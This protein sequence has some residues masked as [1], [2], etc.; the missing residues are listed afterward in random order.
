MVVKTASV[1]F[2]LTNVAVIPETFGKSRTLKATVVIGVFGAL[3]SLIIKGTVVATWKANDPAS[4]NLPFREAGALMM[5][6]A[7]VVL[8]SCGR[9]RRPDGG[10]RRPATPARS[11][12]LEVADIM[13]G[14]NAGV[15]VG[16]IL[17]FWSG[18]S[19]TGYLAIVYFE[20]VQHA[21]AN[22]Q[23]VAG[24][25]SGVPVVMFGLGLG[26]LLSRHLS[27][28]QVAI[29][30]PAAGTVVSLVQFTTTHI[31]QTVV[32]AFVGAPLVHRLRHL[33][34]PHAAAAAAPVGGYGRAAGQ[35]GGPLQPLRRG[36]LVPGRLGG[37]RDRRLPGHL[38]VPGRRRADPGR[39]HD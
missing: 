3:V 37:R 25:I 27:R 10:R 23:T 16:G 29:L 35:T 28:K 15:L 24:Y 17:V 22:V 32:L 6:V 21:G 1:V 18:L 38:A 26:Y 9:P 33:A 14:P 31:W 4:W 39:H 2:G 30:A 8:C 19:A 13:A 12:R 7:V 11:W 34:R 20:K 36:L 5:I